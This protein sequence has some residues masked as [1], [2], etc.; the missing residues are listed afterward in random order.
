MCKIE[1][2]PT[3]RLQSVAD[4]LRADLVGIVAGKSGPILMR[5]SA[6]EIPQ[7]VYFAGTVL[8]FM[9]A[10]G[11]DEYFKKFF[12]RL[13][14]GS[15][16]SL[17]ALLRGNKSPKLPTAV[18]MLAASIE[19]AHSNSL[20]SF[21]TALQ[22]KLP[23]GVDLDLW[24]S[25]HREEAARE[26]AICFARMDDIEELFDNEEA[27]GRNVLAPRIIAEDGRLNLYWIDRETLQD[28]Q[29]ALESCS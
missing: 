23:S 24:L 16:D 4:G 18:D 8:V 20:V 10:L 22:I 12:G 17:I 9:K 11:L 2:V 13:G 19:K 29:L 15:A 21:Q 3:E 5:K 6:G 14:E 28:R 7:Y 1:V 26:I 27:E 25:E